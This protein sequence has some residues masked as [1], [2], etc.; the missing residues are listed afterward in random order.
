MLSSRFARAAAITLLSGAAL[1]LPVSALGASAAPAQGA[2]PAVP[3][4]TAV[5]AGTAASDAVITPAV[6]PS[7]T[8][9]ASGGSWTWQ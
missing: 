7:P 3:A 9:T 6:V 2:V 8:P 5:T 1:A 4:V